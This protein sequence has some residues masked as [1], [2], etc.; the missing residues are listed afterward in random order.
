VTGHESS[1]QS[2]TISYR[3]PLMAIEMKTLT[4]HITANV[5]MINSELMDIVSSFKTKTIEKNSYLLKAGQ[6]CDSYYFIDDGAFKIYT[7][8]ND[9]EITS[10]F[11][12]KDSFFTELESYSTKSPSRF[13][14]KAIEKSTVFYISRK[15]MDRFMD[16][17]PKWNDFVR[18]TWEFSFVKLQQVVLSFQSQSAVERYEDLFTYPD[19]IQKTKQ[20]DL[21]SMIGIT[22]FSLSRLRRKR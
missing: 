21:A 3:Q 20:V 4:N 7:V 5:S 2:P 10:W 18:K 6:T 9:K 11:A 1:P 22:K 12:F 17:Y 8:I 15:T 16:K 14:I 19:F 13:N